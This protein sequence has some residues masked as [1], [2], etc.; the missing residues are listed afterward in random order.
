MV[1]CF[2]RCNYIHNISN[3]TQPPFNDMFCRGERLG[4]I[5]LVDET[6]M[7]LAQNS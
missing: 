6:L 7:Y 2:N 5:L 1:G 4:G 3:I